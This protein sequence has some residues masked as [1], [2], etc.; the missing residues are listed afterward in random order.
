[1]PDEEPAE[2]QVDIAPAT[3]A[4]EPQPPADVAEPG[5]ELDEPAIYSLWSL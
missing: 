4:E 2:T 3:E 1:V 5:D